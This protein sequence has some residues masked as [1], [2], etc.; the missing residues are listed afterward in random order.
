MGAKVMYMDISYSPDKLDGN[1][2]IIQPVY[3]QKSEWKWSHDRPPFRHL[4]SVI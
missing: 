1:R 4:A 3:L 2:M